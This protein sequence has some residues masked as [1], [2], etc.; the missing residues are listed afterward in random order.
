MSFVITNGTDYISKQ[1]R[2]YVK[3]RSS[4]QAFKFPTKEAALNIFNNQINKKDRASMFLREITSG[5]NKSVVADPAAKDVVTDMPKVSKHFTTSEFKVPEN[6]NG[7]VNRLKELNGLALE[8]KT[9]N[10]VLC[11]SLSEVDKKIAAAHHYIEGSHFNVCGG[12]KAYKMLQDLL[13]ERRQIKNEQEV[14]RYILSNKLTDTIGADV[15]KVIDKIQKKEYE[16]KT[17]T[18]LFETK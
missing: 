16:P 7:W 1:N 13:I 17:L 18:E 6:V 8:A 15:E 9:R 2:K 14:I 10:D 12:Y 5:N 3:I 4:E 11:T